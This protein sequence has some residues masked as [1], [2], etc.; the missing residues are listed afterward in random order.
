VFIRPMRVRLD[1]DDPGRQKRSLIA[2]V[3][4]RWFSCFYMLRRLVEERAAVTTLFIANKISH[5]LPNEEGW[6]NAEWAVNL[7]DQLEMFS[8]E[9]EPSHSVTASQV[10]L[11]WPVNRSFRE[12]E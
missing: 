10:T 7:L 8:R 4:T 11:C 6:Q 1:T 3:K 2:D 9:M 12:W 5:E